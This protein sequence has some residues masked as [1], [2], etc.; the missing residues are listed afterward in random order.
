MDPPYLSFEVGAA[1]ANGAYDLGLGCLSCIVIGAG[2]GAATMV[3]IAAV[4]AQSPA[5]QHFVSL[6]ETITVRWKR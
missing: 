5:S 1:G 3:D 4:R 2:L 6:S